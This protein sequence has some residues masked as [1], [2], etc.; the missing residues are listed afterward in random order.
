[1]S[2]PKLGDRS[3]GV[4]LTSQGYTI[5]ELFIQ[6][7][8]AVI[9]VGEGGLGGADITKVTALANNAIAKYDSAAKS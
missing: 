6:D 1:M 2:A 8:P 5:A 4:A 9:Q 3:V 7:G